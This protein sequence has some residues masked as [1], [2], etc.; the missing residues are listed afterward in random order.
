MSVV[1]HSDAIITNIGFYAHYESLVQDENDTGRSCD[2]LSPWPPLVMTPRSDDRVCLAFPDVALRLTNGGHQ[3]EGR[4]ELRYNGSWGTVCDD[5]WDLRDAQ[6][7]CRQLGCGVAVA[8][9]GQAHFRRGLGPIVLDDVECVGTEARL[10]QCL[11]HSW[12]THNCSHHEDASAI[13]S[14]GPDS[15]QGW[16][17]DILFYESWP[18][19]TQAPCTIPATPISCSLAVAWPCLPSRGPGLVLGLAASSSMTSTAREGSPPWS[20]A[21]MA[22]GSPT[23]AGTMRMLASSAQ[24]S[25]GPS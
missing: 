18:N 4:V 6:V 16:A 2:R 10:W 24:V 25:E 12:L 13:C 21:L 17:R 22:V 9:P 8:A 20:T 23:T 15:E 5:S 7:V 3:C 11:H 19:S 14:G 1:F